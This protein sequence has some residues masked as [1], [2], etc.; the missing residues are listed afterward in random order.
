MIRKT[1]VLGEVF[2]SKLLL[3]DI[4]STPAP[5]ELEGVTFGVVAAEPLVYDPEGVGGCMVG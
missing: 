4:F 5:V 3:G 2:P 1:Y